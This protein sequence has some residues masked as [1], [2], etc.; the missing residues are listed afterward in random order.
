MADIE[1]SLTGLRC[2]VL[3][4]EFLIALDIQQI[5]ESAGARDVTCVAS[6]ADA[7]AV[8]QTSEKFDFAV[9]DVKLNGADR[10]SLEVASELHRLR[11]PFI[12][13]TGM[14]ADEISTAKYPAAPVV[15]KPYQAPLLLDAIARAFKRR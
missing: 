6:V 10:T 3:D 7:L 1:I 13:L 11:V 15:E 9:L 2:L 14:R 12:L 4:D 5:L 8:L